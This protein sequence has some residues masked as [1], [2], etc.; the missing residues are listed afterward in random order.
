[1]SRGIHEA[2]YQLAI[3]LTQG[4]GIQPDP[5]RAAAL[6]AQGAEGG[7]RGSMRG[8]GACYQSGYGVA[9]DGDAALR[10]YTEAARRGDPEAWLALGG[11]HSNDSEHEVA[12]RCFERAARLG[13]HDAL[14][15]LALAH[16]RGQ[17]VPQDDRQ[18]RRLTVRAAEAGHPEAQYWLGNYYRFGEGEFEQDIERAV[19]WYERAAFSEHPMA[20]YSLGLHTLL[21][22]GVE[23][24][25]Q[26][27][28]DLIEKA[29]KLGAAD[30][31]MCMATMIES[32]QAPI[33]DPSEALNWYQRAA[34]Q[35]NAEAQFITAQRLLEIPNE[36]RFARDYLSKAAA[37][38]N[39]DAKALLESLYP[40]FGELA[41]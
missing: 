14:F 17:G 21:G 36:K 39:P 10:W 8:L 24:D 18:M 35:G 6:Y 12:V 40:A 30:A 22:H 28:W 20:T 25:I 13:N 41:G 1:V 27:G 33:D 37:Q 11:M 3:R 16:G 5:D 34:D 15:A 23:Q 32:G 38:G 4:Q 2:R 19:D 31:M 7:H 26:E 9:A 29:A